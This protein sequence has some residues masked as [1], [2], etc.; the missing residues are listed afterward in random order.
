VLADILHD[1]GS[2][3]VFV[4][5]RFCAAILHQCRAYRVIDFPITSYAASQQIATDL[6]AQEQPS[7]L[8]SLERCGMNAE[9]RYANM[10][11]VDISPQTAKIDLLFQQFPESIGI[12]DGGN[13][14][15]MGNLWHAIQAEALPII[16]CT[17]PVKHLVIATVS[18]WAA[19]GIA[20]Y[21]SR[22]QQADF[23]RFV[24]PR[25]LLEQLVAWGCVDGVSGQPTLSVDGFP[26]EHIE[27]LIDCLRAEARRTL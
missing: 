18:N 23:M 13:E 12:G 15:G 14:I 5:D 26:L 16:P 10:R 8:I 3:P 27:A 22:M 19:Y 25:P 21:L 7:L 1:L 9:G 2:E 11:H 24:T 6:L 20:A 4:T 17:T